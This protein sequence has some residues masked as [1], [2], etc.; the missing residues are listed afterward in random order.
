MHYKRILYKRVHLW[1]PLNSQL[2]KYNQEE[3]SYKSARVHQERGRGVERTPAREAAQSRTP[4]SAASPALAG[5]GGVATRLR[6]PKAVANLRRRLGETREDRA[7]QSRIVLSASRAP[8]VPHCFICEV[9]SFLPPSSV[10]LPPPTPGF[11]Q[12]TEVLSNYS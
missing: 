6:L 11:S 9:R 8:L 3:L 1:V 7:F 12:L 5:A 4:E 2:L 10:S